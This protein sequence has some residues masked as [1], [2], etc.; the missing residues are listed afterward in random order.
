MIIK[1]NENEHIPVLLNEVLEGL[2]LQPNGFYI[3]CTFGRGGHSRAILQ[4]LSSRGRLLVFDKDISAIKHAKKL[5][6]NEDR[7]IYV[8]GSFTSLITKIE[9]LQMLGKVDGLLFDLGVSS[10]QLDNESYGFSFMR[11]G[12]LDMR[13]DIS[14]GMSVAEWLSEVTL[15]DIERVIRDYGEER[16]ARRIAKAIIRARNESPIT[17]TVQLANIISDAAPTVER[18]KNPATRTFQAFRIHI[19]NELEELRLVLN[20]VQKVLRTGGRLLVISFHSLE[21]R[22]V[23]QFMR[24]EAKGDDYPPEIPVKFNDIC[25]RLRII[26][27]AIKPGAEEIKRNPRARS[28][29]LRIGEKLAA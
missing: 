23:K 5:F 6:R 16:Y 4:I 28:A 19:N 11:N 20:Q 12:N 13:M 21:D 24:K 27:K 22:I 26:N 7:V 15:P 14:A 10:P 8:H 3:D 2:N 18:N 25:P 9:D 29:I 17:H 1:L